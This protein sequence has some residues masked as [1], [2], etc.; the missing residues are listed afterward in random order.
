MP[1][2]GDTS[3]FTKWKQAIWNTYPKF[4]LTD[5]F[6]FS[7]HNG[8]KCFTQCCADVN[9]FLTPYDILR[10]KRALQMTSEEFLANYTEVLTPDGRGFPAVLLKMREDKLKTCPFVS[11]KGCAIYGDRPWGCRMYPVG[12]ASPDRNNLTDREDVYFLVDQEFPCHGFNE[13]KHWTVAEW[14]R[15]QGVEEYELKGGAYKDITLHSF[16]L[17]G[18]RLNA[19]KSEIFYMA[20]YDMDRFKRFVF[21]STFLNRF[22]I[23]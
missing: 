6:K 16:F 15:S 8:L 22:D 18:N 2:A 4:S 13:E 12:M 19:Q 11:E 5:T 10:M 1:Y 14:K 20:C 21:D 7:C 23:A 3:A 9:I 17:E